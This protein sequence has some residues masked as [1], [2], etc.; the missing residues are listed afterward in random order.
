MRILSYN[1]PKTLQVSL[2]SSRLVLQGIAAGIGTSDLFTRIFHNIL[3]LFVCWIN[4]ENTTRS[5]S[6]VK[7]RF[8][9]GPLLLFFSLRRF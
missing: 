4:E 3:E 9:D 1:Y 2:Y 6:I 5:S 7:L 8:F